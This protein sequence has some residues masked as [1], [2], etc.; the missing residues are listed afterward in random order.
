ML[1]YKNVACIDGTYINQ[2]SVYEICTTERQVRLTTGMAAVGGVIALVA[3]IVALFYR[4]KQQLRVV[5]YANGLNCWCLEKEEVDVD[6]PFDAFISFSHEDYTFV[7]EQLLPGLEKEPYAFRICIH[8]RDWVAG[9]WIPAQITRSVE[10]SRRT[11]IVLSTNYLNSSWGMLE[12]RTAHLNTVR[13]GR[14]RII[15]VVLDDIVNDERLDT[16][17][18]SYLRTNTYVRYDDPWF[19]KKLRYAMPHRRRRRITDLEQQ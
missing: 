16:E 2:V 3:I 18:R 7:A 6:W 12:F 8:Y 13:D 4:Y 19:W 9:E 14:P 11:I 15:V 17:L 5:M 1:D 10:Q